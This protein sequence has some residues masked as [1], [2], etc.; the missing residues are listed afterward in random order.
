MPVF[1]RRRQPCKQPASPLPLSACFWCRRS[2]PW[3]RT[4]R[5]RARCLAIAEALPGVTF[6]NFTPAQARAEGEVTHH[7][8]RPLDLHHRNAGRRAHRHRFQ[9]RLR[10]LPAAARRHHEQGAPHPLFG[11]AR[12]G[13]RI[14][15]A[16]LEPRGRAGQTRRWWST[17]SIS[18]TCQPTSAGSASWSATAT[19]SSS[20]RSRAC[21]SAISAI[22]TPG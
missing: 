14:C 13:Y 20:L 2:P 18:A 9:R 17:T 15:A 8:C 7:L 19:R 6:A 12:P 16:R 21:A 10:L 1:P 11:P 4:N 22:C 5:C 3:R